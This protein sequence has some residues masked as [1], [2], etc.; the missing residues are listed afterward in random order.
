MSINEPFFEIVEYCIEFGGGRYTVF[1]KH[2]VSQNPHS[3]YS[4]KIRVHSVYKVRST[5]YI[6]LRQRKVIHH[7]V[8][9]RTIVH[10]IELWCM[11]YLKSIQ[12]MLCKST[13]H[14]NVEYYILTIVQFKKCFESNPYFNITCYM[15]F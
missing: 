10:C 15:S 13:M 2:T 12:L 9:L 7:W 14:S 1:L 5:L 4:R 11:L 3:I 8:H 6:I